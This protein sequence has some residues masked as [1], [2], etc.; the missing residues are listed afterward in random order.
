[1][2]LFIFKMIWREA[3]GSLRHFLS[4][5]FSIALGVGS[6]V[7]VGII[8]AT[9]GG[10]SPGCNLPGGCKQAVPVQ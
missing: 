8:A 1:M 3:R 4:F 9:A 2:A 7:A 10:G 5:L 6:I